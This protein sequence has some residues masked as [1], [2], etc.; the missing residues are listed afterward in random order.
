MSVRLLVCHFIDATRKPC[1]LL[2]SAGS[3]DSGAWVREKR[4]GA[5]RESEGNVAPYPHAQEVPE[6]ASGWCD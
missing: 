5:W 3:S 1:F 4:E 6:T 2:S